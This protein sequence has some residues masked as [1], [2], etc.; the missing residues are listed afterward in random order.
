MIDRALYAL[1]SCLSLEENLQFLEELALKNHIFAYGYYFHNGK[2]IVIS[3]DSRVKSVWYDLYPEDEAKNLEQRSQKII[4][5]N[6]H[7]KMLGLHEASKFFDVEEKILSDIHH[8]GFHAF[9]NLSESL[10]NDMYY[11]LYK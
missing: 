9:K 6:R 4:A 3:A 5:I 10:L 1:D 7:I 8:N 11:K 2:T